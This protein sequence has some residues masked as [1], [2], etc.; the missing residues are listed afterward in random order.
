MFYT[1][2]ISVTLW[3]LNMSKG[4]GEKA[5]RKLRDRRGE[6]LFVDLRTWDENIEKYTYGKNKNKKKTVLTPEQIARVKDI[7]ESWRCV[8]GGYEDV[9]E[10]CKSVHVK[11]DGSN[12]ITIESR[13]YALTP[14]KYIEFIDHDLDIDYEREMGRIQAEMKELLATEKKSQ[15]KLEVAF[16]GIGYGI[17]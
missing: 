14:S 10:L 17:E 12:Q 7:F 13:G 15:V 4:A 5:G 6:V 1:T 8:G 3:I 9:P 16:E 11:S 2:D